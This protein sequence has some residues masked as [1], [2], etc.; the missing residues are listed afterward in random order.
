MGLISVETASVCPSCGGPLE[1]VE[2]GVFL[3]FGCRRCMRYV[4]R[5]KRDFV[6]RFVDYRSRSFNWS[7]MMAELYRLYLGT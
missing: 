3:W 7:G 5:G 4:K 1:L 2:D 6:K